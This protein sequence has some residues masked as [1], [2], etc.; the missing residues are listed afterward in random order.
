MPVNDIIL[1]EDYNAIHRK[2]VDVI[3]SGSGTFGYGQVVQSTEVASNSI[4][5]KAQWDAL[6]FDITNSI[7]HQTGAVPAITNVSTTT[8]IRY[9]PTN[10]NTQYDTLA[11]QARSSRF[12][13]GADQFVTE[14]AITLS[15]TD[16][17]N[18]GVSGVMTAT[19]SNSDQARYFFNS[20]GKIRFVSSRI[21]G[22]STAQNNSWSSILSA[23]GQREISI[24]SSTLNVTQLTDAYQTILLETASSPYSSNTYRVE[25]KCNSANNIN[26]TATVYDIRA[27]WS[28]PY[29]DPP[30]G[31]PGQ[32]PP[33]D[34]VDGTLSFVVDQIRASGNLVPSGSFTIASPVY[35][36]TSISG[37]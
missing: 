20:G 14:S 21:G 15:R 1:A 27:T 37:S 24:N 26:L 30:G 9:G 12:N 36:A 23:A 31:D 2:I 8:V 19:F 17:W 6:R 5:T 28:D 35:S 3:G 25:I 22:S 11:E 29:T 16:S 13:L 18:G 34:T 4:I 7:V 10:P 33:D 32:F